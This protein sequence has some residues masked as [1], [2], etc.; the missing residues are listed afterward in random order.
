MDVK[1]GTKDYQLHLCEALLCIGI[2][3]RILSYHMAIET[4]ACFFLAIM[5][6]PKFKLFI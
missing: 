3:Y 5:L 4:L 6:S 1:G 2:A